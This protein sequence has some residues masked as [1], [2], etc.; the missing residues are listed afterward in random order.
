MQK[1]KRLQNYRNSCQKK[2]LSVACYLQLHAFREVLRTG[3]LYKET[4]DSTFFCPIT[5]MIYI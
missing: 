5:G 2:I 4:I 3:S 1:Q